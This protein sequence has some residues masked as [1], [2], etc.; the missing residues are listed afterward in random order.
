M[1]VRGRAGQPGV[2]L[3]RVHQPKGLEPKST[4]RPLCPIPSPAPKPEACISSLHAGEVRTTRQKLVK[5]WREHRRACICCQ[6]DRGSGEHSEGLPP[7]RWAQPLHPEGC[8]APQA[9]SGKRRGRQ[10]KR[11][12]HS[13]A[14]L[15]VRVLVAQLYPTLLWPCGLMPS[16]LLCPWDSQARILKRVAISFSRGSFQPRNRTQVSCTASRFFTVSASGR[17]YLRTILDQ[18]PRNNDNRVNSAQMHKRDASV[19]GC[20]KS[21]WVIGLL[22]WSWPWVVSYGCLDQC[23]GALQAVLT[24][25]FSVT[26][27]WCRCHLVT[28]TLM[29][30]PLRNWCREGAGGTEGTPLS[31]G[32]HTLRLPPRVLGQSI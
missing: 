1:G 32:D 8:Y 28:P 18:L 15:Q 13:K 30:L 2:P 29:V 12:P 4:E 27:Q 9:L 21:Q 31:P 22:P 6:A 24:P 17:S 23:P 19:S 10:R 25:Y 7:F 14:T 11:W 26:G 20:F 3:A 16:T 5:G